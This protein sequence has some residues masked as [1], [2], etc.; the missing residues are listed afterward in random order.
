MEQI[1]RE[2]LKEIDIQK[3]FITRGDNEGE[4]IVYNYISAPGYYSDNS[5]KTR[6]YTVLLNIYSNKDIEKTKENVFEA[7]IKAGFKGG[8]IQKTE[9]EVIKEVTYYN[10]P[11]TFKKALGN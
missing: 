5:E 1:I 4:C 7:M 11:M 2:A 3:F 6:K 8:Q 10:T 9:K